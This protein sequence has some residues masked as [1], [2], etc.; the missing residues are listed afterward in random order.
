M[1]KCKYYDQFQEEREQRHE[2]SKYS[3]VLPFFQRLYI[4]FLVNDDDPDLVINFDETSASAKELKEVGKV[5]CDSTIG[6][7]P[8]RQSE[9]KRKLVTLSCGVSASGKRIPPI[10]LMRNL[11]VTGEFNLTRPHFDFGPYGFQYS[12]KGYQMKVNM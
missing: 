2:P 3:N 1:Q 8:Q 5:Q 10:Y 4:A 9:D 11:T 12:P 7:R 6:V